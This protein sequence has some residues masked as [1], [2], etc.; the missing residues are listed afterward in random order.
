[1]RNHFDTQEAKAVRL[2]RQALRRGQGFD[3][4]AERARLVNFWRQCAESNAAYRPHNGAWWWVFTWNHSF[5]RLLMPKLRA[6]QE[7]RE[8]EAR[9]RQA[10]ALREA[11]RK[12]EQTK[13]E[14]AAAKVRAKSPQVDL[15]DAQEKAP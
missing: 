12:W 13:A 2:R 7:E 3:A 11:S 8:R 10:A 14:R 15:V 1:M 6:R 9:E 4:L 5:Q